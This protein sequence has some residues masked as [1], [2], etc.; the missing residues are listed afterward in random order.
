[1]VPP[2]PPPSRLQVQPAEHSLQQLT[3][4]Q[5]RALVFTPRT[6]YI[7]DLYNTAVTYHHRRQRS[8]TNQNLLLSKSQESLSSRLQTVPKLPTIVSTSQTNESSMASFD[9]DDPQL[10]STSTI[11]KTPRSEIISATNMTTLRKKQSVK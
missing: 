2:S 11:N 8:H 5:R 4:L 3:S 7:L 9:R 6:K 1:M 10:R